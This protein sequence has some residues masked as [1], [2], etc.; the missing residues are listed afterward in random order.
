MSRLLVTLLTATTIF[1]G[2]GVSSFNLIM[3]MM[4]G[5]IKLN[6]LSLLSLILMLTCH[7]FGLFGM[8]YLFTVSGCLVSCGLMYW[9]DLSIDDIIVN[10]S[11]F[12]NNPTFNNISNETETDSKNVQIK[13]IDSYRVEYV[14]KL[15]SKFNIKDEIIEKSKKKY[16]QLST[17]FDTMYSDFTIYMAKFRESTRDIV[18]LNYVYTGYDSVMK[19]IGLLETVKN[20]FKTLRTADNMLK[21][22]TIQS[23]QPVSDTNESKSSTRSNDNLDLNLGLDLGGISGLGMGDFKDMQ[24]QF[25]SLTPEQKKDMDEMAKQMLSGFGGLDQMMSMFGGMPGLSN[26][27]LNNKAKKKKK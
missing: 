23:I 18:G 6:Y 14:N 17:A 24:K 5:L 25:D 4:I 21:N 20:T 3:L 7:F 2:F 1:F 8:F 15:C 9:Y 16:E 27:K 10:T 11:K 12:V 13:S 19:M 22:K 26:M